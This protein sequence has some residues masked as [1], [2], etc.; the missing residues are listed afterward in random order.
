MT[1]NNPRFPSTRRVADIAADLGVHDDDL[2]SYGDQMA[3]VRLRAMDRPRTRSKPPRLILV[4]ATTPTRAGEGK[5]TT[6]IGL[7]QAFGRIGESACLALREAS[8]GP[9]LGIKGGATGGGRSQLYPAECINLH[10][11][12]DFHAITSANNL[13]S[14]MIDNHIYHGNSLGLDPRL[15]VWPHLKS[16]RSCVWQTV[17]TTCVAAWTVF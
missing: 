16:W 6:S 5:T 17:W 12:G 8:L 1:N 14:A 3:K 15:I 2:L 10:F 7:G 9:C 11:T 4:S 13:V